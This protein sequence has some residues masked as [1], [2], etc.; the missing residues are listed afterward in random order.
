MSDLDFIF[1]PR[2]VAIVGASHDVTKRGYQAVRALLDAHYQGTIIPVNPRGGELLGLPVATTIP[3][4][5]LALICTPAHTVADI[6][7]ECARAG[8]PGAVV[9]ALGFA[10]TGADGERLEQELRTAARETG[11]RVVGPNTSGIMN[12]QIGLNLIGV[13]GAQ[14]GS[15]ALLVQSGNMAL[16]LL[17]QTMN[18][19]HEGISICIGAG[20]Q[21]DLSLAD[22]LRYLD[23]DASTSAIVMY[24]ESMKDGRAFYDAARAPTRRTPIVLLKGGRSAAG[25]T[26][27]KSHT[28][29]LAGAYPVFRT[30]MRAAGVVQ[31]TR[32]DELFPVVE[33]LALQPALRGGIAVLSDGGGYATL[34]ADALSELGAPIAKLSAHTTDRLRALLGPNAALQN[35]IDMANAADAAPRI[36]GDALRLLMAD[37]NV[38]GVLV[39]GLF[40]GYAIRF[41]EILA[42]QELDAARTMAQTAREHGKTLI[43]HSMYAHHHTKS[44]QTLRRERVPLIASL[45]VACRAIAAAAEWGAW[46]VPQPSAQ[47]VRRLADPLPAPALETDVRDLLT[48]YGAPLVPARFCRTPE[49]AA[50]AVAALGPVALKVVAPSIVHKSDVGGVVLNVSSGT[51]AAS[52]FARLMALAADAHGVLAAQMLDKPIAELLIGAHRD[53][54]FGAVLTIGAGGTLVELQRDVA[55]R[56]LPV[57]ADEVSAML[58]E[59]IVGRVLAGARG[60]EHADR[61]AVIDLALRVGECFLAHDEIAELELNPVFVYANGVVGVDARGSRDGGEEAAHDR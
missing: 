8:V 29:A 35:P 1:R 28:G 16:S 39:T 37:E 48:A 60:R 57:T 19:E 26:I 58:D 42:E 34:T 20:N 6:I 52:I 54:Q 10:E 14:P 3:Q 41:A 27:A 56:L 17:N 59:T 25:S 43:V 31:V 12:L 9:L 2:S 55:L 46:S 49:E 33:A 53:A 7:R 44:L 23:C 15:I 38:G 4:A 61:A 5:D 13:R 51:A 50:A 21:A 32:S 47:H 24:V 36:F 22:Y 45:D 40:G 30:A 11:V 18:G